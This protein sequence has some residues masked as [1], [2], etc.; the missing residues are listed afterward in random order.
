MNAGGWRTAA[1]TGRQRGSSCARG[2]RSRPV[3]DLVNGSAPARAAAVPFQGRRGRLHLDGGLRKHVPRLLRLV[4]FLDAVQSRVQEVQPLLVPLLP[5]L[6][7][8]PLCGQPGAVQ[9]QIQ[10][11]ILRRSAGKCGT[12]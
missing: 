6:P 5:L 3:A 12:A 10:I 8:R 11:Q 7:L 9:I 2:V 4:P 1:A